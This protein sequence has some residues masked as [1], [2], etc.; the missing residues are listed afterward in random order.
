ML[1]KWHD[2]CSKTVVLLI[3]SRWGGKELIYLQGLEILAV[4]WHI[5]RYDLV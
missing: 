2:R 3:F 5:S 4:W 1:F